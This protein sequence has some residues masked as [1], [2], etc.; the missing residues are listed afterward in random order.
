MKTNRSPLRWALLMISFFTSLTFVPIPESEVSTSESGRV[1]VG[2]LLLSSNSTGLG[3]SNSNQV[4]KLHWLGRL[5]SLL[6]VFAAAGYFVRSASIPHEYRRSAIPLR[7]KRLFLK[8]LQ[9]QSN[10]VS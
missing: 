1:T 10:Y 9:Y 4:H 6:L 8:P 5:L 2:Q 7:L 3:H